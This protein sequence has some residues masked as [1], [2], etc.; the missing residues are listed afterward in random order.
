MVGRCVPIVR[1]HTYPV[2]RQIDLQPVCCGSSLCFACAKPNYSRNQ[3]DDWLLRLI[4]LKLRHQR[5]VKMTQYATCSVTITPA[6]LHV[7]VASWMSVRKTGSGRNGAKLR[8]TNKGQVE[9]TAPKLLDFRWTGGALRLW[10]GRPLEGCVRRD[11]HTHR[12]RLNANGVWY[13]LV[14]FRSAPRR[15]GRAGFRRRVVVLSPMRIVK[16]PAR[17]AVM[18]TAVSLPSFQAISTVQPPRA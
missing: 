13:H 4:D 14:G 8:G 2:A 5:W 7:V 3:L 17:M 11:A 15:R 9:Y 6:P 16:V 10:I 18:L 12:Y 1:W